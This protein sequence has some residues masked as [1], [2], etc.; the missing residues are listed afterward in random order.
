MTE[1][2]LFSLRQRS[3]VSTIAVR[4]N[5]LARQ[6][7]RTSV[8]RRIASD[9]LAERFGGV[10]MKA[11]MALAC[12]RLYRLLGTASSAPKCRLLFAS[13]FM[14]ERQRALRICVDE[15]HRS[16]CHRC[17]HRKMSSKRALPRSALSGG[18]SNDVH[19]PIS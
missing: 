9:T 11:H 19:N 5:T 15:E 17:L 6:G 16:V 2:G 10:S 18:E 1:Y 7:I 12:S 4:S 14:P 3:I 13:D 8:A